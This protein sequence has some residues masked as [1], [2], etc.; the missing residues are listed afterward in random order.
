VTTPVSFDKKPLRDLSHDR[1]PRYAALALGFEVPPVALS[2]ADEVI[3]RCRSTKQ[4]DGSNWVILDPAENLES[5]ASLES[6][7]PL[8]F[9]AITMTAC[10]AKVRF[11]QEVEYQ[12]LA[13]GRRLRTP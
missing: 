1:P 4:P 3:I 6:W 9:A 13:Q 10:A 2:T 12:D 7:D 8:C 11:L 5:I